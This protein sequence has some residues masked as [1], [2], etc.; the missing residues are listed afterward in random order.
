M[1]WVDINKQD[2]L[3]PNYRSRLVAKEINKHSMPEM[4]AATPALE[5]LK[6]VTSCAVNGDFNDEHDPVKLMVTDVSRAYFYAKAIRPVYLK[7]A[8]EDCLPGEEG[9][10]GRLNYSTYRTRDA[11]LNW[12]H[13]YKEHLVSLSFRQGRASPCLF[14]HL[15]KE[16]RVFVFMVM[17]M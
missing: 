16:I 10:C 7:L 13:H 3:H 14:Y 15:T 8:P 4:Y 12:H 11:A 1:R 9:M 17:I 6:A 2:E 5:S